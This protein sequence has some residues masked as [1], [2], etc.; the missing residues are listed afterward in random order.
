MRAYGILAIFF[1]L[2]GGVNKN[3][4]IVEVEDPFAGD[5]ESPALRTLVLSSSQNVAEMANTLQ[6]W[7]HDHDYKFQA[8]S[9]TGQAESILLQ[10]WNGTIV[11]LASNRL[12]NGGSRIPGLNITIYW[13]GEVAND[14]LLDTVSEQ[15][16]GVLTPFGTIEVTSAPPGTPPR[17]QSTNRWRR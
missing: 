14:S 5:F 10:I 11:I 6:E 16:N 7:A 9:P 12:G 4:S 8:S 2:S 17:K 3:M 13:D 15:I 1:M